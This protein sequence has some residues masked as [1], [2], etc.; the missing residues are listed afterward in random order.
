MEGTAE[1]CGKIYRAFWTCEGIFS[2]TW[3]VI[4]RVVHWTYTMMIRPVLTYDSKDWGA[5]GQIHSRTELIRLQ[6]LTN[7]DDEEN[8]NSCNRISFCNFL[9]MW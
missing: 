4:P 2:K 8:P 3:A 9:L 7:R 5:E 6:R 1:K